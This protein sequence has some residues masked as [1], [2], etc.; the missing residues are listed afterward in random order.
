MANLVSLCTGKSFDTTK[1]VVKTNQ[2]IQMSGYHDDRYVVYN[3]LSTQ[4]GINYQLINLRTKKFG[5]CNLIQPLSEKFGI[6]Y[7]FNNTTPEFMDAFEVCLL[8]SE[9]E[10][11]R[12][13]EEE[14]RQAEHKRTEELKIIGRERFKAILPSNAQAV[15]IAE[16]RQNESDTMTDYYGHS[17]T[18]TV[19][20]GFSTHNTSVNN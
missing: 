1:Q 3:I 20:L 17:T 16:K 9:A 19:I 15:I 4:F 12:Q 6:G 2:I 14:E 18:R 11:N 13:A 8:K 7:Y 10:Q 5:Q